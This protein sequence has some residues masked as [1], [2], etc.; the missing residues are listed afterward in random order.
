[1]ANAL[2]LDGIGAKALIG[3]AEIGL[4]EGVGLPRQ[5]R[6]NVDALLRNRQRIVRDFVDE[7]TRES[8]PGI[9]E[10]RAEKNLLAVLRGDASTND[11]E[12]ARRKANAQGD[13][14]DT[15]TG[16]P[17]CQ[18]TGYEQWFGWNN[19]NDNTQDYVWC[20]KKVK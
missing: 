17:V 13:F 9:E 14:D 19:K 15:S 2:F 18:G 12:G 3:P 8:A 20:L 6:Q 16:G 4:G 11:R 5:R 7:A 1:M 10:R